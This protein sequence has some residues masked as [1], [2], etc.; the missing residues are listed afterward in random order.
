MKFEYMERCED[1]ID[2]ASYWLI[3]EDNKVTRHY[4]RACFSDF[5]HLGK[6]WRGEPDIKYTDV[7]VAHMCPH[8]FSTL[9]QQEYWRAVKNYPTWAK[10][11]SWDEENEAFHVR[12][13]DL[14]QHA[15][16]TL[17]FML[18][19]FYSPTRGD[20]VYC[21][22]RDKGL[23]IRD[24]LGLSGLGWRLSENN[25]KCWDRGHGFGGVEISLR[26]WKNWRA[27]KGNACGHKYKDTHSYS[28]GRVQQYITGSDLR[29][30]II[31]N[32]LEDFNTRVLTPLLKEN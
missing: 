23:G 30:V 15:L 22:L 14:D 7:K 16:V 10:N 13:G 3:K 28:Y 5:A 24:A 8:L 1:R 27:G 25:P 17:L 19:E 32:S 18:R 9:P 2:T 21:K 6:G 20:E 29:G 31:I 11:I 26:G 4:E 12:F